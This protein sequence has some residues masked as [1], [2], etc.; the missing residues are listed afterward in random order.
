MAELSQA[1][2]QAR[3]AAFRRGKHA[4]AYR[5]R[6]DV[7][8]KEI[9]RQRSPKQKAG[10]RARWRAYYKRNR[11]RILTRRRAQYR[12][13]ETEVRARTLAYHRARWLVLKHDPGF[14]AKVRAYLQRPDVMARR[15]A[16]QRAYRKTARWKAWR[17]A[18][19]QRPDVKARRRISAKRCKTKGVA[20]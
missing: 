12:R 11:V 18:Y 17:R 10:D 3:R 5:K 1:R 14:R 8:A 13:P 7:K 2:K 16:A 9:A 19:A 20:R 6:P 15:R 4:R